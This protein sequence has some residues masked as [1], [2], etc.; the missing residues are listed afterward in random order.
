M[1]FMEA[2]YKFTTFKIVPPQMM[3]AIL[4]KVGLKGRGEE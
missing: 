1:L 2:I 4:I 3:S